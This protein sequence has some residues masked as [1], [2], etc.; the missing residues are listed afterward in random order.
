[1]VRILCKKCGTRIMVD[2]MDV[3]HRVQEAVGKLVLEHLVKGPGHEV[4]VTI[5]D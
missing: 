3:W 5:S 1:M 2:D 4:T